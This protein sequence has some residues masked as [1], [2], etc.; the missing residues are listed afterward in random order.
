VDVL[1]S[2]EQETERF[3]RE[4]ASRLR[5]DDVVYLRGELGVGKTCLVRGIAEGLGALPRQVASPTFAI[6]NEYAD[7]R[8]Q[9]VLRHLDLYRLRDDPKDVEVLGLPESLAGAPVAVEWP[10]QT[11]RRL[12]PPTVEVEIEPDADG[13]RRFKV[14]ESSRRASSP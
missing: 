5:I 6:L 9:I 2:S 11:I 7:S 3:G 8:G 4:L 1:T 10:A 12:L 14:S 13:R